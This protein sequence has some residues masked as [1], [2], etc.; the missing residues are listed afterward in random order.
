MFGFKL[1]R[2]K[3]YLHLLAT[4]KDFSDLQRTHIAAVRS[5]QMLQDELVS[6]RQKVI[7][8]QESKADNLSQYCIIKDRNCKCELCKTESEHC[9][10]LVFA[11]RT[12]CVV[13]KDKV[14][15]FV[16]PKKQNKK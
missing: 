5:L 9:K 16:K 2:E 7:D 3:E 12:I 4:A 1:V 10:K 11:D 8:L 14:N 13:P 15:S 6:I